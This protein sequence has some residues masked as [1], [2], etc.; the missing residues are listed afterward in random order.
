MD[1][2]Y[3][4]HKNYAVATMVMVVGV[5]TVAGGV[6]EGV[7]VIAGGLVLAAL[8]RAVRVSDRSP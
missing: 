1:A 2:R 3:L 6:S 8:A 7:Y 4:A 5:L